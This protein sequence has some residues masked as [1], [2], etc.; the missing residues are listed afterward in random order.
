MYSV[1]THYW[2][3]GDEDKNLVDEAAHRKRQ[4]EVIKVNEFLIVHIRVC[5][6]QRSRN[7][8]QVDQGQSIQVTINLL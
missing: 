1:K 6:L 4:S 8:F 5:Y 2:P 3:Q 7:P